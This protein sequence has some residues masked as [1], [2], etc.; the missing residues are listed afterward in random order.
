MLS[1]VKD[2]L[3]ARKIRVAT[4]YIRRQ[5]FFTLLGQT[6]GYSMMVMPA[7]DDDD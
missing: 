3:Y 5:I 6:E 7:G 4:I 1:Y 2:W